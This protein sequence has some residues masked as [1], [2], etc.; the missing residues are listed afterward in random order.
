MGFNPR[1]LECYE[2]DILPRNGP[3]CFSLSF[4]IFLFILYLFFLPILQSPSPSKVHQGLVLFSTTVPL[5]H[6]ARRNPS[7]L[8][9]CM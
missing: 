1:L 8:P 2:G 6:L 4:L 9:R 5:R 7:F 3:R